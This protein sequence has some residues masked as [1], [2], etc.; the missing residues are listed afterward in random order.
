[1]IRARPAVVL[2]LAA[3]FVCIAGLWPRLSHSDNLLSRI[4]HTNEG[5]LS[6]NPS[7]SGEGRHVAF[8]STEDLASAGGANSFRAFQ[9]GL[10][11]KPAE[12]LQIALS[13]AVAPGISQDGSHIVFASSSYLLGQNAD[14]NSEIFLFSGNLKQITKTTAASL[15]TR[16]QDGNF[17]PSLSDDGR[18]IAFASNR[19]FNSQNADANLEVFLFDNN[20][21]AFT[22]ITNS[23]N[24]VGASK[25]K[26]SCDGSHIAYVLDT[27]TAL[28]PH[29]DL[30]LHDRVASTVQIIATDASTVGLTY[31]RAIS[32]DGTRVV[33]SLE[34]AINTTQV[35]L[36]EARSGFTRQLTSLGARAIDVPLNATVSGDGKRIA[37]ATR[38]N[39]VTTNNDGGAELFL[40]DLPTGQFSQLTNAPGAAT[41]EIVCSLSDDG[42]VAAFNFPR[43]LS[44]AIA[45]NDFAN[46]S[47]IYTIT[48]GPRASSGAATILNAAS[49]SN[50]P[51]SPKAIAHDSIAVVQGGALASIA[52]QPQP[53]NDGSFPLSVG[54]TTVSVNGRLAQIL[55]VSPGQV[56]FVTPRE[57]AVG[58][59][60]VVVTNSEGFQSIGSAMVLST[61]PG[62][63][64]FN[65]DGLGDAVIL[66]ADTLVRAPF[67]PTNGTLRLLIFA[68]GARNG[69]HVTASMGGQAV[70]VEAVLT[71]PELPGLDEIHLLVPSG[72]RGTGTLD[73][74]L[75]S[76]N[77]ASNSVTTTLSGSALSDISINEVLAD[78]PAG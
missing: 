14:G 73:V 27:G 37:F 47:E 62:V 68:T 77:Q 50:D 22:Q 43:V 21:Q 49:L 35:F 75:Q 66:D 30:V 32:D 18:F 48:I 11:T 15:N 16:V 40:Y 8:E 57:T 46:N 9:A 67:D 38:R 51:S 2:I 23:T 44:E 36:F 34:T 33:Y 76:D 63:F 71:S 53:L 10:A 3:L 58:P 59:A 65:G 28:D 78:P 31:G 60:T 61:A 12:F 69:S 56:N 1:M 39:V 26:I 41:A 54:G 7:I 19:D 24:V 74:E 45:N 72:L 55:Y 17:Q 6:L 5:R 13:R 20:T 42:G 64:T 70:T 52:Q 25:V 4:T 29:R